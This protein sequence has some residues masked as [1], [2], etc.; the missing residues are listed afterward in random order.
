MEILFALFRWC[1]VRPGR[2]DRCQR[3]A[4]RGSERHDHRHGAAPMPRRG[5]MKRAAGTSARQWPVLDSDMSEGRLAEAVSLGIVL[6]GIVC[7]GWWT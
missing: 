5:L 4:L 3:H 6:G 1:A 2:G 7:I